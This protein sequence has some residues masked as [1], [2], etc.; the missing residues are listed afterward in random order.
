MTLS[1]KNIF[2]LFCLLIIT[3]AIAML[4]PSQKRQMAIKKTA[5]RKALLQKQMSEH[6]KPI[7]PQQQLF[8]QKDALQNL[9][10]NVLENCFEV[11]NVNF[12]GVTEQNETDAH[13]IN[14]KWNF[15]RQPRTDDNIRFIKETVNNVI[16]TTT[17]D[18][19]Q[20]DPKA[21][22]MQEQI[23]K[24][25][26]ERMVANAI[27]ESILQDISKSLSWCT[28]TAEYKRITLGLLLVN[29]I[30]EKFPDKNQHI[31]YTSLASGSLLQ[32]YI[33][34]SELLLSHTNFLVNFIDLEYPDI[35][36]LAIKDLR[37][38]KPGN[39]HLLE[40]KT[41]QESA[42]MIDSF[43]I[44]MAQ[45]ISEKKSNNEDYNFEVNIYQNAYEYIARIHKNPDE[46][47]NVLILVDPSVG[48][49]GMSD[50]PS[51]ANVINVLIDQ[52]TEP[53]FTIYLPRHHRAHLYQLKDIDAPKIMQY[54]QGQLIALIAKT[55][56]NKNY[57]P[58]LV[59]A[60]LDKVIISEQ[61][62]DEVLAKD[63]PLI[64]QARANLK[65]L[66][67]EEGDEN[68]VVDLLQPLTPVKLGDKPVLLSWGTDA[69]ISFQDL[70]WDA[71]APNA[72]V[73]Q[74][75]ATNPTELSD[76]N[77]QIIKVNPEEYKKTD[78]VIPNAGKSSDA[79]YKR[80][81]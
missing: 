17:M 57:T 51:L 18:S 31:V 21:K 45:V 42:D 65:Q 22:A 58:R 68:Y 8:A 9:V 29:E 77:D 4:T 73:Y 72:I 11:L 55:G 81:L 3:P 1:L 7:M 59:R 40:M 71:L 13:V 30:R 67:F 27:I 12:P 79:E 37:A 16:N 5:A 63:F 78:V 46:K 28:C 56:A 24:G 15:E 66:M 49:F 25:M 26:L 74:L 41:Q 23:L 34:L 61:I 80:I 70:V 44:K 52:T 36:A 39:L 75:Y 32:D 38:E 43:K 60:F 64:M 2:N 69:H 50:F 54:L 62:T 19:M 76:E 48:S 20:F 53:V 6:F 35:P 33:V 10:K 47:S 14:I